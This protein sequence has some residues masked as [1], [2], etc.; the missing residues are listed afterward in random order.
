MTRHE[1]K[2]QSVEISPVSNP[3]YQLRKLFNTHSKEQ[4]VFIGED[5]TM[6][7]IENMDSTRKPEPVRTKRIVATGLLT[8]V[9]LLLS[10]GLMVFANHGPAGS[11][12]VDVGPASPDYGFPMWY[13]DANGLILEPCLDPNL[14]FFFPP[15][16]GAPIAFPDNFADELFF[17]AA[18]AL[19][20]DATPADPSDPA[21]KLG[22]AILTLGLEG[23]FLNG[24]VVP[25]E[26][27]VF[28]RIRL[29][30][31]NLVQG[32]TYT[33]THPYGVDTFVIGQDGGPGVIGG[34]GISFVE[35]I[36]IGELGDFT[37]ALRSRIGP[38]LTWDPATAPPPPPGYIADGGLTLQQ[39]VGSPF[40]ANFFRVE[41]V[42]VGA[43]GSVHLCADPALGPDPVATTD[44]IETDLFAVQGK[45]A[46]RFGVAINQT[47]YSR[48]S[49]GA[50]SVNTFARSVTGQLQTI[51]T[52]DPILGTIAL[53]GNTA[54]S[55]FGQKNFAGSPP[56]FLTTT[57][58]SDNPQTAVSTPLVDIVT[59]T[60]AEFNL[61]TGLLT[62]EAASS[63]AYA[64]P[65]L[66]AVGYGDLVGGSI[67]VPGLPIP[68]AQV[69][70]A[71][72]AGGTDTEPVR[73]ISANQNLAPIAGDDAV[74]TAEET[75]VTFNVLVNDS[76]PDGTIITTSVILADLPANGS[77]VNHGDGALTYTPNV[78]FTGS[79]SFTYTVQDNGGATSSKATVTLTVTNIN[80]APVAVD[81]DAIANPIDVLTNDYDID[82]A[83][84]P[85]TVTII[86]LPVNGTAVPN[87][88]GTITYTPTVGYVGSD[89]FTYTVNDNSGAVSNAANVNVTITNGAP[90]VVVSAPANGDSFV[91]GTAVTFTGQA[92]DNEDGDISAN[93]AWSSD[94]DGALGTGATLSVNG[95]SAGTHT[96]TA[97]VSDSS[98]LAASDS[99]AITILGGSSPVA[100]GPVH[101]T[102]GFPV[103]YQDS[104]GTILEVCLDGQ[105][106]LCGFLPG[107]YPDLNSP[108]SFPNNFPQEAF[109]WL[110]ESLILNGGQR[111]IL[112]MAL[113][114]TFAN[115]TVI[116]GDQVSSGYVEIRIDSLVPGATYTVTHPYGVAVLTADAQG[117][118]RT[119]TDIGADIPGDF[120]GAFN[121]LPGPFLQWSPLSDAPAGYLGHP[122]LEHQVMGSPFGANFFRIEGPD[123]G[124]PGVNTLETDL[125]TVIGKLATAATGPGNTA[126]AVTIDAPLTGGLFNQGT[127]VSFTATVTDAEEPALGSQLV[128]SSNVDGQLGTGAA[129]SLATLSPGA[130]TITASVV[131]SGGLTA[132]ANVS[133]TINAAPAIN[134]TAPTNG[135][136]FTGGTAV[137][138]SGAA[139]DL[140]DGDLSAGLVW[141]SDLDGVIGAGASFTTAALSAGTHTITAAAADSNGLSGQAVVTVTISAAPSNTAPTLTI[142]S[143][144]NG[145]S[146]EAGTAVTF[147]G[148]AND[149]EDG[150]LSASISWTSD[151]NG[152]LGTGASLSIA[153]LSVGTHTITASVTDSGGLTTTAT[154][155]VT[156]TAVPVDIVT[157]TRGEYETKKLKWRI[158]G[159]GSE[160]GSI[161]TIYIGPAVGG[162]VLATNIVVDSLGNW[163]FS[164]SSS[165]V[166]PDSTG[167]ISISS[168]GGGIQEGF[169]L[170]I[171]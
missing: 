149:L 126:P 110:A 30:V 98:G 46:T 52:S 47:N 56:A 17:W 61:D 24:D 42:N 143:P 134:I 158:E 88:D 80:D 41:G 45:L 117:A 71:S 4:F 29:R 108:I 128:W 165:S 82:G 81:D 148:A 155:T 60:R 156:I 83:L 90:I 152:A 129:L 137:T 92:A 133:I 10:F 113:S 171:K 123:A 142:T 100:H 66:T 32:E 72:A 76:D 55:Y 151:Q 21:N 138:F 13:Q 6:K 35:D 33:V 11:H 121:A 130:H 3:H 67:I 168:S 161:I 74:T 58:I 64:P 96:I 54:G 131:D 166:F 40:G 27:V 106:P 8:A 160:P 31:D 119:I 135:S 170:K 1:I 112:T 12:L 62:I 36:G 146:F 84:D 5:F 43:P 120:T 109:Y 95:L 86:T 122:F 59:I 73:V 167:R 159:A 18:E 25:G 97:A 7:E 105:D 169:R 51:E 28:G 63:D 118:I 44:C 104:L 15:D 101:P 107:D 2:E 132:A 79:D 99:I 141:T 39:V 144:A 50:G 34:P 49:Q 103:W 116:S 23:A 85:S 102:Y 91:Q 65:V 93:L 57:N 38:F 37:G 127:A 125:F 157:V 163:R 22:R 162:Q 48:N 20:V 140:E 19:M 87:L 124:G 136:T 111:A 115:T 153:T 75:A 164:Q 77:V 16:P 78:N 69:T 150:D 53:T 68:P 14:C 147:S 9:L 145:N 94:L 70:V 154:V 89:S 139:N 114:G 26:Q